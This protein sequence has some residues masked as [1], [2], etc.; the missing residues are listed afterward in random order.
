MRQ[1]RTEIPPP[2]PPPAHAAAA[3][4]KKQ[5]AAKRLRAARVATVRQKLNLPEDTDFQSQVEAARNAMFAKCLVESFDTKAFCASLPHRAV[6]I[7]DV[8]CMGLPGRLAGEG[9]NS[10]GALSDCEGGAEPPLPGELAAY[11][12]PIAFFFPYGSCVLWGFTA[13]EEKEV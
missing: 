12:P 5:T 4:N 2:P 9:D 1:K 6:L 13:A 10:V 11:G 3:P 8:V 7:G